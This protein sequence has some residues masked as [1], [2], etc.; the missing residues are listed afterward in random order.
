MQALAECRNTKR[1]CAVPKPVFALK[2]SPAVPVLAAECQFITERYCC[3]AEG[4][5]RRPSKLALYSNLSAT[6]AIAR[7]P[8]HRS[9][10]HHTFTDELRALIKS[11]KLNKTAGIDGLSIYRYAGHAFAKKIPTFFFN[12]N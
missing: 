11:Q 7:S 3:Q 6:N 2:E 8:P 5:F 12:K 4:A 1:I 9:A 10:Y